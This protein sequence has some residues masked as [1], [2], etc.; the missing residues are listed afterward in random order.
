MYLIAYST[1]GL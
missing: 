1:G